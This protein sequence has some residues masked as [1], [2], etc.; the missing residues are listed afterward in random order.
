MIFLLITSTIGVM[1][2]FGQ[3]YVV[4]KGGP[5]NATLTPLLHIY[6]I[7]IGST[8]GARD[9]RCPGPQLRPDR[10]DARRRL[11]PVP[12]GHASPGGVEP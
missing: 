2:L 11:H 3:P 6:N 1:T 4:T 5:R 10:R 9:R 7:G 12:A 8:G